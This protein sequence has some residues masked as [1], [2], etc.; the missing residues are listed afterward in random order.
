MQAANTPQ[1]GLKPAAAGGK[2]LGAGILAWAFPLQQLPRDEERF[3][4]HDLEIRPTAAT[5]QDK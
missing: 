4:A 1:E 3:K 2:S 5:K